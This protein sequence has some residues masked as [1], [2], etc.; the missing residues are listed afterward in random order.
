M[1]FITKSTDLRLAA[2][3]TLVVF[4]VAACDDASTTTHET[5]FEVDNPDTDTVAPDELAT[6]V[7]GVSRSP[8]PFVAVPVESQTPDEHY[9]CVL[10]DCPQLVN[11][12]RVMHDVLGLSINTTRL[13]TTASLE[14]IRVSERVY[15]REGAESDWSYV[16]DRTASPLSCYDSEC[17]MVLPL[18]AP[19]D[20]ELYEASCRCRVGHYDFASETMTVFVLPGNCSHYGVFDETRQRWLFGHG[21]V[22]YT[23]LTLPTIC[24]V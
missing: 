10:G 11:A 4:A 20:R 2:L 22:S 1:I 19:E 12:E 18:Q 21:P 24:R 3:F 16:E 9:E 17:M 6:C 14:A 13:L 8:S 7:E 23:H 15:Y 5:A